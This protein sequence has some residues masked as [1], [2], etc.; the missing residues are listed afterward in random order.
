[1]PMSICFPLPAR[2]RPLHHWGCALLLLLASL[3]MSNP[4]RADCTAT[5]S[6][7]DLGTVSSFAVASTPQ[8]T[9]AATGFTCDNNGALTLITP[10]TVSVTIQS[11]TG[12][13]GTQ[14]RLHSATTGDYIPYIIC[15]D[16]GCTQP[17]AIGSQITW[18]S[19]TLLGLLG[20]F[21]GPG[22]TLPLYISTIPGTQVAA[23][24]YGS[25]ITLYWQWDVCMLGALGLCVAYDSGTMTTTLD[26]TM[27]VSK[28]CAITAPSVDFGSAAFLASFDPVTQSISITCSKDASYSVGIDNGQQASGG[29][30]RL[31]NGSNFIAYDIYYPASSGTRWGNAA[32]ERRDSSEATSNAG[33]YTGTSAQGFTYR[34]EILSGQTTPPAGTYTDTLMIDVQF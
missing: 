34:A 2:S 9:T 26:V 16:P 10:N 33:L 5:S 14:P 18:T 28:D 17:Y 15:K 3:M 24:T 29:V 27:I 1:M 25:T 22:G 6:S 23:G 11:A 4:A 30:R 32:G 7:T 31:S 13:N 8:S 12:S 21:T 19:T 20:L